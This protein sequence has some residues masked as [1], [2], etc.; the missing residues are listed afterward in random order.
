LRIDISCGSIA[1]SISNKLKAIFKLITKIATGLILPTEDELA[2]L[3]KFAA[4]I[5]FQLP[6]ANREIAKFAALEMDFPLSWLRCSRVATGVRDALR[7]NHIRVN[8][9]AILLRNTQYAEHL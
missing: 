8:L 4:D 7:L 5:Q 3:G 9:A 6:I 1:K 2:A